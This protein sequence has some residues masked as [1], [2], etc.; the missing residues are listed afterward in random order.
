ML[1]HTRRHEPVGRLGTIRGVRRR[2]TLGF[3]VLSLAIALATCFFWW[4]SYRRW[5]VAVAAWPKCG[6]GISSAR[7]HVTLNVKLT[8]RYDWIPTA[9]WSSENPRV[10]RMSGGDYHFSTDPLYRSGWLELNEEAW[11]CEFIKA[12]DPLPPGAPF[13]DL[14][15]RSTFDGYFRLRV[16]HWAIAVVACIP[17]CVFA[18]SRAMQFA[19]AH[20]RAREG[21]CTRCGYDL[22]ETPQRCPECGTARA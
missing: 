1:K 13:S 9:E 17:I 18:I 15:R 4:R 2:V 20:R 3:L 5:D 16:P 19:R 6:S 21:L 12:S 7:G 14:P 11:V 8:Q 22:R 10:F